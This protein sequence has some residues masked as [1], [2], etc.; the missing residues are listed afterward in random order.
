MRRAKS[1]SSRTG[2]RDQNQN[3]GTGEEEALQTGVLGGEA[4]GGK[5]K[6]PFKQAWARSPDT[7]PATHLWESPRVGHGLGRS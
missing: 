7:F 2:G 4:W 3:A 6:K 1:A 5:R